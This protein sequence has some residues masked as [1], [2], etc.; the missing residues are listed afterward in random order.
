[1]SNVTLFFQIAMA[2]IT[3]DKEKETYLKN[4]RLAKAAFRQQISA[5]E[6]KL[7]I[8]EMALE[9]ATDDFRDAVSPKDVITDAKAYMKSIEDA[10]KKLDAAQET[11]DETTN[12]IEYFTKLNEQFLTP[13]ISVPDVE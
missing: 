2:R 11:L 3:G 7:V 1:M 12:S 10:Q 5:L 13:K 6:S 4:E 8:D 9:K